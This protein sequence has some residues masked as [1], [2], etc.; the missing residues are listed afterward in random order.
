LKIADYPTP[1]V[2]VPLVVTAGEF[3]RD[4]LASKNWSPGL[5]ALLFMWSYI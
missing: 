2:F 4:F 1:S 5:C 3:Y